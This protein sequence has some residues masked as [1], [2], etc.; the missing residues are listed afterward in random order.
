MF[1]DLVIVLNICDWNGVRLAI[2]SVCRVSGDTETGAGMNDGLGESL[3]ATNLITSSFITRPS[4]PVPLTSRMLTPWLFN[5]PRTAGTARD[6]CFD[7]GASLGTSGI[8]GALEG[9][10]DAREDSAAWIPA[11]T[12]E[13]AVVPGDSAFGSCGGLSSGYFPSS[14]SISQSAYSNLLV[15]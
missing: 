1:K 7:L 13:A 9:G 15:L 3:S 11:V 8:S 14:T 6:A 5:S 2:D 4:F 12:S 10:G